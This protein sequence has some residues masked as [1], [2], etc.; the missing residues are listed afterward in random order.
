MWIAFI[1]WLLVYTILLTIIAQLIKSFSAVQ[2]FSVLDLAFV[3]LTAISAERLPVQAESVGEVEYIE[4]RIFKEDNFGGFEKLLYDYEWDKIYTMDCSIDEQF[5]HFLEKIKFFF[6][7]AF[8][9]KRIRVRKNATP[10]WLTPEIKESRRKLKLLYKDAK[11]LGVSSL[12]NSFKI[13][14]KKYKRTIREAQRSCYTRKI[15]TSSNKVKGA[16]NVVNSMRRSKNKDVGCLE[17]L[18]EDRV[19]KNPQRICD[20]FNN[21]FVNVSTTTLK[22][23]A[24]NL[25]DGI[26]VP[27]D[28]LTIEE[29]GIDDIEKAISDLK[30]KSTSGDDEISLGLISRFSS[31]FLP[32]LHRFFNGFLQQSLF[33]PALKISRI[34]PLFKGGDPKLVT[35]YRP[36]A[37]TSAFSKIFEKVLATRITEFL[38]EKNLLHASQFGY[39]QNRSTADAINHT[40]EIIVQALEKGWSTVAVFLDL[41]KAFDKVDFSILLSILAH[42]R[43]GNPLI[44]LIHS[45]LYGRQQYVFLVQNGKEYRSSFRSPTCSVPQGSILG[46]LLF[47]LYINW[48]PILAGIEDVCMFCDDTVMGKTPN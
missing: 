18:V 4:K 45:F 47:L 1:S 34:K 15:E 11:E 41:S 26:S 44:R 31:F 38:E 8:P 16:W 42:L 19:V 27:N 6:D 3:P 48:L 14:K 21:F 35:N 37:L 13:E 7:M 5:S 12:R 24:P 29:L 10:E 46:P 33:P 30:N 32:H 2:K 22:G 17:V 39:R 23:V 28:H 25:F 36:I 40:V 43:F 20:I 9:K